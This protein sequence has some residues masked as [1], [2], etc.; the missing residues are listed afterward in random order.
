MEKIGERWERREKREME[1]KR[2]GKVG[3]IDG[4]RMREKRERARNEKF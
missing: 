3:D 4:E 2:N 1:R